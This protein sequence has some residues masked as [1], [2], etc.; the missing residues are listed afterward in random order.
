MR[1]EQKRQSMAA[2]DQFAAQRQAESER[3]W[4]SNREFQK[5]R[6]GT[7]GSNLNNPMTNPAQSAI[8]PYQ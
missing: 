4:A 6:G 3:F 7:G 8:E 5:N 1:E 2:K